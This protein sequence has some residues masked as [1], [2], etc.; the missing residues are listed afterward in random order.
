MG[1]M[2]PH[3]PLAGIGVVRF[4][5]LE[6]GLVVRLSQRDTSAIENPWVSVETHNAPDISAEQ[7]NQALVPACQGNLVVE[8]EV[9][10]IAVEIQQFVGLDLPLPAQSQAQ[11]LQPFL[12][13]LLSRQ[14]AC[15]YLQGFTHFE[16]FGKFLSCK[17]RDKCATISMPN[18]QFAA[19]QP[20]HSFSQWSTAD[21]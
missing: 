21:A 16:Q 12:R 10:P 7:G 3:H 1:K 4:E 17:R 8:V 6:N 19:F 13:N 2:L 14:P 9:V 18:H 20:A 15:F 5:R 11:L